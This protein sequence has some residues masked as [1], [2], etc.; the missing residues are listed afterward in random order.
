MS[1]IASLALHLLEILAILM[2]VLFVYL[3]IGF[4]V[5]RLGLKSEII[6]T[7]LSG[8]IFITSASFMT[9]WIIIQDYP[10]LGYAAGMVSLVFLLLSFGAAYIRLF[11]PN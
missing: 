7:V 2:S 8:M 3:Q 9:T 1:E 10:N 6:K 5:D 4:R 11:A